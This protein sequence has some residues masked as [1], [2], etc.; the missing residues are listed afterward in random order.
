[1]AIIVGNT[2]FTQNL[3][4]K[5]RIIFILAKFYASVKENGKGWGARVTAMHVPMYSTLSTPLCRCLWDCSRIKWARDL[6]Y[7]SIIVVKSYKHVTTFTSQCQNFHTKR[8]VFSMTFLPEDIIICSIPWPFSQNTSSSAPF[9]DLSLRTHHHLLNSMTF[10]PEHIIICSI[11]W[12]F[13][14]STSSSAPF[15]DLSPRAHHHLLHSMTFLPDHIII[16]SIPWPF[17]HSTSSS[18][19]FHDLSPRTHHHLLHSM[20][21]LPEHIIIYSNPWPFSQSTSSSAPFHDLSLRT[22]HHLLHSHWHTACL[23]SLKMAF[24]ATSLQAVLFHCPHSTSSGVMFPV[25]AST[26]SLH[27]NHCPHKWHSLYMV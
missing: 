11:P 3:S 1:M 4:G 25:D 15:H 6:K 23:T 24:G 18:A 26:Q 19:P 17:S 14:Q 16:Y 21:F 8:R 5:H 9:H 27:S 2:I 7:Y 12:P 22:H 20:T 13:S 10:L